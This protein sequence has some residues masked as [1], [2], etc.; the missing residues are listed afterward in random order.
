MSDQ[1]LPD[2]P[3]SPS[4]RVPKWV[5]DEA[6]GE[7]PT[8]LMPFRAPEPL[9]A[10]IAPPK[11]KQ[12]SRE[13]ISI[14]LVIAVVGSLV[15]YTVT[16]SSSKQTVKPIAT[17]TPAI[18]TTSS[19]TPGREEIG[20]PL[21][22]PTAV[23]GATSTSYRFG[24]FQADGVTPA[25]WSPCRPIHYVVRLANQPIE[26]PRIL[27]ESFARLALATGF[28]F[29]NDGFTQEG[30]TQDR[31]PFQKDRYGDK[32]APVLIVWATEDE[33]PDFGTDIVGEASPL[34]LTSPS[35]IVTYVSGTVA[36][37]AAAISRMAQQE[38]YLSARS[39]ALHELAHLVGLAHVNDVS[40]VMAPK[41]QQYAPSDYQPGDVAGLAR[42]GS[43]PCRP[44][45]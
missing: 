23:G 20:R 38:G 11:K 33:V 27:A 44:D 21:G 4:G 29:V 22:Q 15:G 6:R 18:S 37:D 41:H 35:G 39:I 25:T 16:R 9:P 30:P 28:V 34:R 5:L 14:I 8:E 10:Y 40:Q 36:F 17:P 1:D 13:W 31:A 45:V 2:V 3:K 42:L 32:W 26:G 7:A 24:A 12:R 19:P 43:G